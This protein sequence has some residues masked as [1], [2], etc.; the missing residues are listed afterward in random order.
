MG[1]VADEGCFFGKTMDSILDRIGGP[2]DLRGLDEAGLGKLA[3]EVRTLIVETVSRTG[4]HLAANLGVVELTIALLK[5]FAPPADKIVWDVSH[6]TYAYK[7]LTGRRGRFGTLRQYGGI[8]G[9]M[10]REESEYDAFG[11]G[12]S[13][14]AISAALGMAV[15]RDSRGGAGH[16]VAVLGDGSLGCGLSLEG[17]N[18]I[19]HS[20][21]RFIV[22]LNDN[23]MSI[24]ANVGSTA[25][26][27]G[28]LLASPRYNRWKGSVETAA[29]RIYLGWLR[30]FYYRLEEFIK[31]IFLRSVIFE[32]FG[33]RYIGPIDGHNIKALLDALSIAKDYNRP[34]ILHVVTQK[35]RGYVP[36]E[37][38]PEKFHGVPSFDPDTGEILVR[39]PK[40]SYSGVFGKT[41]ERIAEND[42]KVMAITAAMAIGT[43]LSGF[44]A[45]FPKRFF[46]VGIC[47][48]HA[49]VFAAGLATQGMRPVFAVYSTFLQRAVDCIIHDVCLQNLPVVFCLDR[50]GIVGDD[51]PTH[52]GIFDIA[53]LRPV[54][55]L[56]IAQPGNEAEMANLLYSAFRWGK[57]VA[58]RYPRGAGDGSAL[59]AEFSEIPVGSAVELRQGGDVAIWALGDMI[60]AALEAA[61]MLGKRG[62]EAGVVNA[63]FVKPLDGGLLEKQAARARLVVT[64]E[65]GVL[66]GGFGSAVEE[67]LARAGCRTPVLRFGWPDEFVQ[68][69]DRER[70]LREYGLDASSIAGRILEEAGR[71]GGDRKN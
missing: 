4:G 5:T 33:L 55:N 65:N 27:L 11:A 17:F 31:G 1:S 18:N 9:F 15:A 37:E 70:L 71:H 52:H 69:G 51:G 14:T 49:V 43:G 59:P 30:R 6:Q 20:T 57:P 63:R 28:S 64:V 22:V 39:D 25:R 23:E 40:P 3:A 53:L 2:E 61:D 36:A 44:A 48:E 38:K 45:R 12:H 19:A 67:H 58:L 10:R 68:H 34:I 7:I 32:E 26:Y 35:G 54:P 41:I 60:P 66:A 21:G 50:A 56:V 47:E 62:I 29:K 46:D 16:V 8:S 42:E 13:G 24:S